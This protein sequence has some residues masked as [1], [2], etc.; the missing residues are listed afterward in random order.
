MVTHAVT[1]Q[2]RV[3]AVFA[4]LADPTRRSILVRLAAGG[5]DAV[6][7]LAKPFRISRPAI[8]RHLR[9]LERAK[10]ISRRRDGRVHLI[11]ARAAGLKAAQQW[12]SQ[13]AAGWMF[14]FDRLDALIQSDQKKGRKP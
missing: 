11:R 13:M 10:L 8:S 3:S 12:I 6:T 5:E 4:A 2:R 1:D 14:S 7:A 9:V